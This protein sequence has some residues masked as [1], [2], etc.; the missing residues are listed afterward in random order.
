MVGKLVRYEPVEQDR[1]CGTLVWAMSKLIV[2]PES[3]REAGI[4]AGIL[5]RSK[6]QG[7]W[8][9]LICVSQ[10]LVANKHGRTHGI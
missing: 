6:M 4:L 1:S 9:R 7:V 8:R 5:Q 10:T 3:L 2:T